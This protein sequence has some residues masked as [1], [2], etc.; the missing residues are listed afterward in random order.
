LRSSASRR[1]V[2]RRS[3]PALRESV[4]F[5]GLFA[6][7]A[8]GCSS[9]QK[10]SPVGPRGNDASVLDAAGVSDAN[11]EAEAAPFVDAGAE[12][13]DAAACPPYTLNDYNGLILIRKLPDPFLSMDGTRISTL[14]QWPCRRAE[15]SAQAQQ[16]ELGPKPPKPAMVT[17]AMSGG[18][19]TV[20]ASDGM[21]SVSFTATIT[22]PTTGTPPYPAMIGIGGINIGPATL[23]SMGVATIIF[24]NDTV[25]AQVDATSRGQGAFY[26]LYGAT[27]PA[28]AMM[29]WAWGV[30]RLIDALETTP[31]AMI[32]P[33]HL[34]VTGCSRNGKG[35]LIAGA[36][37]E[38]IALT[39]PQESGAG[40]SGGWRIADAQFAS[41]T[42]V[43][44]LSEITGENVWFTS[45]F[46]QF[47]GVSQKLP[48]DHH[49]I[50]GMVAPRGLLIVENTSQIWL[51][52][53]S[54]Y[55]DSMAGQLVFQ[56]LGVP[57]H[58][59]VSQIGD[60]MHCEWNGSQQ[61][62]VT[63]FVQKFLLGNATANT[64]VLKTDGPYTFDTATWV[65][66]T[67]P[68]LQ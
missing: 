44:T 29:A 40:G 53:L 61:P 21:K 42:V 26:D 32:D 55:N 34:G 56:A 43:Q 35:A 41:G 20:T 23:N 51:G 68:T 64:N 39:I 9:A 4:A 30:S 5:L 66:W 54:T 7:C 33:T 50:E 17:G 2:H 15:I 31:D 27:H 1:H 67:V 6:A 49:M 16:Y 18:N 36:F 3:G 10:A 25:A 11:A 60:H 22:L 45:S 52:D 19:L 62:E 46:S 58:M 63:A 37:D 13:T 48:Y 59:G 38:R 12:T 65:D 8:S 47:G 24:P 28:G 14:A 57:D